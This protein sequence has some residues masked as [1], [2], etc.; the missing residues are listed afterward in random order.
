MFSGLLQ[1]L[2][3]NLT[4]LPGIGKKSA[5]RMAIH[6][7]SMEKD[8]AFK[9]AENIEKAVKNYKPCSI[10]NMLSETD[11]CD[12]CKNEKR[13]NNLLCI[14]E[15]TQDVYLINKTGEFRGLFLF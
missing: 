6:I 2:V 12:F 3:N 7:I 14:V 13:D 4:I 8:K 9:I 10:C 11:P 15:N 1:E 5:Q